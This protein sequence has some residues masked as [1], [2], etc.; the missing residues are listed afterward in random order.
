M[1]AF[2]WQVSCG[3]HFFAAVAR[4]GGLY[5]W[6]LDASDGRLGHGR[7][8]AGDRNDDGATEARAVAAAAGEAVEAAARAGG[9]GSAAAGAGGGGSVAAGGSGG[10]GVEGGGAGAGTDVAGRSFWLKAPVRVAALS[11][12][13]VVQVPFFLVFPPWQSIL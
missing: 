4:G 7:R 11:A 9:G 1:P 8:S 6:G 12:D 2:L 3:K 5:T 13:H 10:G